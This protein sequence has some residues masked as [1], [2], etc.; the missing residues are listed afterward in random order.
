MSVNSSSGVS[1][2]DLNN[3]VG[4]GSLSVRGGGG[5]PYVFT[6]TE[7]ETVV[8]A[9]DVE[10]N[11]T[12]KALIDTLVG[13]LK[14]A[15]VW[16]ELDVL[17]VPMAHDFQAG[18][19]NWKNPG[20]RDLI[21]VNVAGYAPNRGLQGDGQVARMRTSYTPST[22]GVN[23]TQN[24]ASMWYWSMID[25]NEAR[26]VT[27]SMTGPRALLQPKNSTNIIFGLNDGGT[28]SVANSNGSGFF[29]VQRR[30]A[31]DLR[32][33]RNGAQVG[34]TS[35]TA[36]TGV[37][38]QEQW[39]L[40]GNSSAFSLNEVAFAAWGASLSGKETAFYN[41]VSAYVSAARD[42]STWDTGEPM[43]TFPGLTYITVGA[44]ALKY[45]Y[46]QAWTCIA[47]VKLF[48]KP[49]EASMIFTNVS[50]ASAFPGYELWINENGKLHIRV[51]NNITTNFIGVYGT[52]V[53]DDGEWHV[54]AGSYDGSGTAAGVKLYVDGVL[55]TMVT[56]S[57]TLS[58]QSITGGV[59]TFRVGNQTNH[60]DFNLLGHMGYFS[61]SDVVRDATYIAAHATP[62]TRETVDSD[63]SL[64][65]DFSE[66]SGTTVTDL[67]ASALNGT[68]YSVA[69][70]RG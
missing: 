38:N 7:A 32:A 54:L 55:E 23:F 19:V 48:R 53:L 28:G 51:I 21:E 47:P 30:G 12:R 69:M 67:S 50:N 44:D 45:E 1:G 14:A 3:G 37:T 2:A 42:D 63:H 9:F 49:V 26:T 65:Y 20:T 17:Y 6:N 18:L 46:T 24:S 70:W 10:P 29:G 39:L 57:D 56:E 59:Q 4:V 58:G 36:S 13:A 34:S 35:T 8:N 33:W 62:A 52:T 40:G 5:G 11:N 41:A 66:G 16:E 25:L 22:D 61:L 15:A 27:G 31:S 64:F 43:L 60:F 68:L